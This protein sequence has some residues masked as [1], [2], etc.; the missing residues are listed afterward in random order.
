MYG[1]DFQEFTLGIDYRIPIGLRRELA[2]VRN[3]QLKLAR[4][5]ARVEDMELDVTREISEAVR[6]LD[7]NRRL[8][9]SSF[10]RWKDTVLEE[11]HF[12][13]IVE[14]GLETLDVALDAQRRKT[15]ASAAFYAALCEYNKVIAILHRRKGTIL[16]YNGIQFAEGQWSGK[17]YQDATEYARRRGAS[18]QINYG[19][20]R[21]QVI[22]PGSIY[23][24]ADNN[25]ATAA[26]APT[27]NYIGQPISTEYYDSGNSIVQPGEVQPILNG[28]VQDN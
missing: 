9:Q 8:M 26:V 4:D 1:G 18:R 12:Q 14:L 13:Q 23:P 3:A 20:T 11:E 10:N 2:N 24:T 6:A 28:P 7:A 19:W 27:E 15:Q 25:G 17:A 21:P 22:S 5:I 16:A